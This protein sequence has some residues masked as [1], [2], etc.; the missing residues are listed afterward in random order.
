MKALFR[1]ALLGLVAGWGAF[2]FAMI[3]FSSQVSGD[4]A[5]ESTYNLGPL[6][7]FTQ[8]AVDGGTTMSLGP[9]AAVYLLAGVMLG[10]FVAFLIVRI[11]NNNMRPP[12]AQR[13]DTSIQ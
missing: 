10:A 4:S 7:V 3:R 2:M 13:I 11:N 6:R 1:G 8:R 12:T 5:L 9:G